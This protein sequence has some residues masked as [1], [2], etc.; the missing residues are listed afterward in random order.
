MCVYEF[1]CMHVNESVDDCIQEEDL[2]QS[3]FTFSSILKACGSI[4]DIRE[5]KP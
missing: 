5:S 2:S 4:R 1:I 3:N